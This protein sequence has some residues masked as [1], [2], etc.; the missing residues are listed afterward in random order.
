MNTSSARPPA[1]VWPP[2]EHTDAGRDRVRTLV[3]RV[4]VLPMLSAMYVLAA[5]LYTVAFQR[6]E[7]ES[8][9]W[10]IFAIAGAAVLGAAAFTGQR[11]VAHRLITIVLLLIGA[12]ANWMAVDV[13]LSLVPNID[14]VIGYL[15]NTTPW[16]AWPHVVIL[17]LTACAVVQQLVPSPGMPTIHRDLERSLRSVLAIVF[18]AAG[19]GCGWLAI[20]ALYGP[21]P[22]TTLGFLLA[23]VAATTLVVSSYAIS[24]QA[25]GGRRMSRRMDD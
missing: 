4:P 20:Q 6:I 21:H 15:G 12:L 11:G 8:F 9:I 18:A 13:W 25:D 10:S 16:Y 14:Y 17:G 5:T 23:F 2:N 3:W 1:E 22:P 24:A 19:I 7:G